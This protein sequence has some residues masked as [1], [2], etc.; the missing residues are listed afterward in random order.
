MTVG[1][2]VD[3]V[4]RF[5]RLCECHLYTAPRNQ[6]A[7]I[8]VISNKNALLLPCD[9]ENFRIRDTLW[10]GSAELGRIVAE[11]FEVGEQPSVST[12]VKQKFHTWDGGVPR[13][14]S[15]A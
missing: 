8:P 6:L 1:G 4:F 10:I 7:E 15:T 2:L 12:L 3:T 5:N 14:S 9:G 11:L 13:F